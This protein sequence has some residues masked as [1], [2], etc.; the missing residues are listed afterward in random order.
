MYEY[1][2]H[3]TYHILYKNACNNKIHSIKWHIEY[4]I[5]LLSI[6]K[7]KANAEKNF[8]TIHMS[9]YSSKKI[10]K[11]KNIHRPKGALTQLCSG[12]A[13]VHLWRTDILPPYETVNLLPLLLRQ[14]YAHSFWYLCYSHFSCLWP[15]ISYVTLHATQCAANANWQTENISQNT[16]ISSVTWFNFGTPAVSSIPLTPSHRPAKHW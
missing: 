7:R 3:S 15:V 16:R 14:T 11:K 13:H 4:L 5:P 8:V 12:R 1:T 9:S 2:T 6:T 10:Q